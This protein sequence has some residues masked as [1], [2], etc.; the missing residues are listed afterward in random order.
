MWTEKLK[1]YFGSALS[2]LSETELKQNEE[3]KALWY[4]Q[5]Q[6][7]VSKIFQ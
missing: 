7:I 1:Y 6:K 5:A 2:L 3:K 4:D